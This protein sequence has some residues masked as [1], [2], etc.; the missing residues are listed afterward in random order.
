MPTGKIQIC[1]LTLVPF[2]PHCCDKV[3]FL[4][5]FCWPNWMTQWLTFLLA[6]LMVNEVVTTTKPHSTQ[7]L[8]EKRG[9]EMRQTC[10]GFKT[11]AGWI[12]TFMRPRVVPWHKREITVKLT[13]AFFI[14]SQRSSEDVY[15]QGTSHVIACS[16]DLCLLWKP[17]MPLCFPLQV[18]SGLVERWTRVSFSLWK[19]TGKHPDINLG[20][21][22]RR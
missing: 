18:A 22:R 11:T 5:F 16:S 6:D 17:I 14:P 12:R 9:W 2:S 15:V 4:F 19:F 1:P 21:P 8:G 13:E 10:T 7:S 20:N 3:V